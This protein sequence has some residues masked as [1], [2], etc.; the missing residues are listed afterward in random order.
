MGHYGLYA[1]SFAKKQK[2]A[3]P[4]PSPFLLLNNISLKEIYIELTYYSYSNLY[5][6]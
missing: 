1:I 3:A 6:Y 2:D 4:I 5:N